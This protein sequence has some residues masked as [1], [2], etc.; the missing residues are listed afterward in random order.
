MA[1][2]L[3]VI[4]GAGPVGLATA[5][6]FQ[7]RGVSVRFVTRSGKPVTLPGATQP[8]ETRQA[9][10][11]DAVALARAAEGATILVHA[12]GL[13]YPQWAVGLPPLQDAVL[14]V[15]EK[16][17]AVVVFVENL[18]S[19]DAS[20]LPLT[21]KT[22]EV[23][24]T[25]KGALRLK[26]SQQWLAQHQ[27]G[28]VKAVSVRASDYF[29]PGATRS[30]NSHFGSR[31]FPGFEAGKSVA[32]LGSADAKHCYTYL[33]DY[34]RAL[35]DVALTPDAWGQVW[36]CPSVGPLTAREM[37]AQFCQVAQIAVKVGTLPKILLQGLGLFDAMI[38]ELGEMLYQF[39]RPFTLDASAFEA[40]FGWK[41]TPVEVAVADTWKAHTQAANNHS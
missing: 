40:R 10:A 29:G 35:A 4:L 7:K 5:A 8:I 1:T 19:Y 18:Y 34:A 16:T 3:A 32:F 6:E 33:P 24:P 23:P 22:A 14:Q 15:A 27:A 39:D 31:F 37:T 30:G 11:S 36:I 38:R 25:R 21:E 17:G 26:L 9:D 13:P 41:A 12:V 20:T 28:K 2:S